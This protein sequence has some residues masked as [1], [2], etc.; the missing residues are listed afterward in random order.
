[1][2]VNF[3]AFS[4]VWLQNDYRINC[5]EIDYSDTGAAKEVN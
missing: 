5:I 1:M 4:L 3:Q 2:Y